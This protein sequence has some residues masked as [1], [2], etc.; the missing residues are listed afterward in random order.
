MKTGLRR[1][2]I[3]IISGM[4]MGL[5]FSADSLARDADEPGRRLTIV[6]QG[7]KRSCKV[8]YPP[9]LL[10]EDKRAPLV[11]VLHGGGGNADHAE[12]MT[13]FTE[14][15]LSENFI[16]AYPEG[17][18]RFGK[19]LTWN[20]GHCCGWAMKQRVDDVG[21]IDALLTELIK[22][23][24]VDPRRIY[25]TG[26]SNGG[27]MTHRLGSALSHRIAAIAPVIAA[28]FG[29]EAQPARPVSAI[30]I[31]GMKDESVPWQGGP[32]GGRFSDAWDQTPVRPALEQAVFWAAANGCEMKPDRRETSEVVLAQ[33]RCPEGRAVELHLVKDNG[34]AWPGGEPGSRRGDKPVSS[35]RATNV[36]WEFFKAHPGAMPE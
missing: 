21:F 1:C 28:L 35:P 23:Y 29:D 12:R 24:P 9:A 7:I 36:I 5:A 31:N 17:T 19:F 26:L 10:T 20:A 27:M 6:H 34:H 2:S 30:M 16:V 11:L 14:K 4:M 22:N 32:P 25:V 3:F 13:G 8:Q 18:G 15:A 33:F